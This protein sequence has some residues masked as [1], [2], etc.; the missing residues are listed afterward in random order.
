V[1]CLNEWRRLKK[2]KKE[3]RKSRFFQF[4]DLPV[5]STVVVY[6]PVKEGVQ[7]TLMHRVVSLCNVFVNGTCKNL[8][9]RKKNRCFF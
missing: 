1:V 7:G 8:I 6:T 5:T 2:E 9:Y 3:K 4:A